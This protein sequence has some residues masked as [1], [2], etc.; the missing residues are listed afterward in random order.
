L[1]GGAITRPFF[2]HIKEDWYECI[3]SDAKTNDHGPGQRGEGLGSGGGRPLLRRGKE[4]WN[5]MNTK[6]KPSNDSRMVTFLWGV[7]VLANLKLHSTIT[8]GVEH[9]AIYTSSP[10]HAKETRLTGMWKL[11][12]LALTRVL[13]MVTRLNWWWI[14][15][16]TLRSMLKH[17][18]SDGS[19]LMGGVGT[20][21][22][23]VA[24]HYYQRSGTPRDLYIITTA[25]KRDSAD[26]DVEAAA[27]GID[28][29]PVDGH[30]P[31]LVVDSW[32]NIKKYVETSGAFFIFDEQ[33]LVGS[34]AWVK[35][36]LRIAKQNRW[37]LL[38]GTPGDVWTDYIPVFVANGFYRN[39]TDFKHK[40]LVYSYYG[41]YP[42][43]ERVL[44]ERHLE[45]LRKQIIVDMAFERKT[46]RHLEQVRVGYNRDLFKEV[47][48]TRQDPGTGT[49]YQDISG[50]VAG[51][52]R[53]TNTDPS[54]LDAVRKIYGARR[55][56]IVFYNYDYEREEL[57]KLW[58]DVERRR[59]D[60]VSATL[61]QW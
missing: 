29:R 46:K 40:H 30:S 10:R 34:G 48:R 28:A 26:W 41:G 38:S 37:I 27:A 44:G 25:R 2:F 8:K 53:I 23:Q 3:R 24:L 35:A 17:P 60:G 36:F 12:R 56:V 50:L 19:F 49:P 22:S 55:R 59:T 43:L 31:K 11:L 16:T 54:R 61:A 1:E 57:L 21:N 7:W 47:V 6:R 51:L 33:R 9:L 20:G 14:R 15:G 45:R 42:K 4:A 52:R 18:R 5:S 39:R 58:E 13:S 32:N